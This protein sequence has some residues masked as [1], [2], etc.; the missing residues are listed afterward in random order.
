ML[1]WVQHPQ[2]PDDPDY[3]VYMDVYTAKEV[4][5]WVCVYRCNGEIWVVDGPEGNCGEEPQVAGTYT[6]L[7]KACLAAEML[8]VTMDN[9]TALTP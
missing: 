9:S 6:T 7:E 2:R 3:S 5:L 1:E 4:R 8:A